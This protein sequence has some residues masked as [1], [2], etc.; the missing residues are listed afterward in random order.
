MYKRHSL[1]VKLEAISLYESGYGSTTIGRLLSIN[2]SHIRSWIRTYG[3]SGAEGLKKKSYIQPTSDLRRDVVGE[4]LEKCLSCESVAHT[5]GLSVYAVK[6]WVSKVRAHGYDAL[7]EIK[8][9]GRPS[10][11]MGRPK[12]R[13][14][15]TE[16]EKLREE[17]A[18]LKAENALLKK[19]KALVEER[20]ARLRGTGQKPS[21]D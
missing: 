8:P 21:K 6:S 11:Y 12:K 13:E 5:Y 1:E 10:K 2:E 14:P 19:V 16:L 20:E 4:V 18:R 9:R 15:Q 3:R 17:N 7:A